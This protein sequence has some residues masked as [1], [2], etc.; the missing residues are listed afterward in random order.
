MQAKEQIKKFFDHWLEGDIVKM[1]L[2]CQKT[3]V[4]NNPKNALKDM[5]PKRIKAYKIERI[6]EHDDTAII[7][8][9]ITIRL[10]GVEKKVTPRFVR[11]IAPYS[12]SKDPKKGELGINPISLTKYL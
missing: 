8:A 7:D 10:G 11:E 3:W 5:I 1:Y 9:D 4:N 6:I 2:S 12:P